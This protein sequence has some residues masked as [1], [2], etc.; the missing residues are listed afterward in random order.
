ME[1]L[2]G[3]VILFA[4]VSF[5]ARL[6]HAVWRA[7]HEIQKKRTSQE[8]ERYNEQQ[9]DYEQQPGETART[10][11]EIPSERPVFSPSKDKTG[12][13]EQD[14]QELRLDG[15]LEVQRMDEQG[16][17]QMDPDRDWR[18]DSESTWGEDWKNKLEET[19]REAREYI[20]KVQEEMEQEESEYIE[21][22]RVIYPGMKLE[23]SSKAILQGIILSEALQKRPMKRKTYR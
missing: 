3:L 22:K 6:I 20:R 2:F 11:Y 8:Y 17:S 7:H 14:A 23:L 1:E 16:E 5:V 9:P 13:G 15:D 21:R 12:L 4:I 19:H 18:V 10:Q